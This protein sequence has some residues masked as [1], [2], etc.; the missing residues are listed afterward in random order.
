LSPDTLEL[1]V[2]VGLSTSLFA[3]TIALAQHDIK[4]VLAYSTVSQL[5]LMFLALGL[6]AFSSGIFHMATH[7]FFKALLFLG[8]GSVIHALHHEQDLRNMGGLKKYLPITYIT[9]LI[10]VLAISGIPPL[11]GFFSKD[12]I[13]ANAFAHNKIVWGLA[14]S[15]SL[16]TVLYMFRLLFLTF[17]GTTRVAEDQLNHIHESP[18]S[19]TTPLILLAL[20]SVI[21]GFMGIPEALGGSHWLNDFLSPVFAPSKELVEAHHLSHTAEYLLMAVVISFTLLVIVI[22]F[23]RYVIKNHVPVEAEKI[24]MPLHRVFY[25]KYYVDQLYDLAI[26]RPLFWISMR[27][28]T[29]VE[30]LGIDRLINAS[31]SAVIGGSRIARLLQNGRIGYYIFIMVIGIAAMLGYVIIR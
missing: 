2:V 10:G 23:S 16:L 25:N 11:A 6:G 30:Q 12:E 29:I 5:G 28:D 14:V 27:L 21:G 7:A 17:F 4:K 3:A 15:A 22:A 31:G 24:T 20:L 8:A 19:I 13:L 18:K 9:F 1:I 26:V